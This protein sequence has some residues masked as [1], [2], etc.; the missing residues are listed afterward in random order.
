MDDEPK[1]HGDSARASVWAGLAWFSSPQ[2]L[3]GAAIGF[4]LAVAA[5][6][7]VEL[8]VGRAAL[9][10][11]L[12]ALIALALIAG[13]ASRQIQER[14]DALVADGGE[15]L[16]L[17]LSASRQVVATALTPP[18][19]RSDEEIVV[20]G[21]ASETLH[22]EVRDL[23]SL[24]FGLVSRFLALARLAGVLGGAISLAI[25]LAT[26][27]QVERLDVQNQRIR[28]QNRLVAIQNELQEASRRA[29]LLPELTAV[30]ADVRAS[31]RSGQP[32][33]EDTLSRVVNL[34]AALRPY[35]VM[36]FQSTVGRDVAVDL[37]YT[38]ASG[39]Q[40]ASLS[41]RPLSPERGQLLLSLLAAP[42]TLLGDLWELRPD[43]RQVD[44]AETRLA[45]M[46]LS[47]L[48][49]EL[50]SFDRVS[51][52]LA[53][54]RSAS[55]SGASFEEATLL[56][57]DFTKSDVQVASSP[58]NWTDLR[59]SS[60]RGARL[61]R[62]N[63]SGADLTGAVMAEAVLFDTMFEDATMKGVDLEGAVVWSIDPDE[64][65]A[66]ADRRLSLLLSHLPEAERSRWA[67]RRENPETHPF[68]GGSA[69][70]TEYLVVRSTDPVD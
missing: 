41:D 60:F 14:I 63:F 70:T 68:L 21:T 15:H 44:L 29:V 40:S 22:Q 34:A 17:L 45:G 13:I 35:R 36:E 37:D 3:T 61:N 24:A 4:S 27:M 62:A 55:L 32:L 39:S 8:G 50:G 16:H 53:L 2:L 33:T 11:A 69:D 25:F 56:G 66:E 64:G 6:L 5:F 7:G 42:P 54:F 43:F 1:Q 18:E 51:A 57:A 58:R 48:R 9:A 19:D 26:L 38:E 10:L 12:A 67:G 30:T 52:T 49:L 20:A 31:T 46:D 65:S 59:G 47:H 23:G 28:E